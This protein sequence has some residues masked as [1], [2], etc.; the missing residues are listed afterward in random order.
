MAGSP[1]ETLVVALPT[2]TGREAYVAQCE[3]AYHATTPHSVR[4]IIDRRIDRP[5]CGEVWNSVAER[6]QLFAAGDPGVV[7]FHATADDLEPLPGWYEAAVWHAD[8]GHSPSALIYTARPGQ[9]D[10]VESHGDWGVRY[11]AAQVVSMSRIP[12]CKAHQWIPIP[13]IHYFSDNA[14]SSAMFAQGI[15]MV[16]DPAFAFRHWWAQSGRHAMN[17]A[18]WFAEQ[19]A[20]QAWATGELLQRAPRWS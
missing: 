15:P 6:A 11:P 17:D 9:P 3:A 2:V 20:W 7:Y 1:I 19:S 13:P 12:F 14:F 8:N 4:L 10:V 5:T 16:A 18:Q